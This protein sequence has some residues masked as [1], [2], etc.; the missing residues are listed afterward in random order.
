MNINKPTQDKKDHVELCVLLVIPCFR[1]DRDN[2]NINDN[3]FISMSN[4][5]I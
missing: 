1:Q 5:I 4:K 2:Y 3:D